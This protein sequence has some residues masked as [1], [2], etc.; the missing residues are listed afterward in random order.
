MGDSSSSLVTEPAARAEIR[1]PLAAGATLVL[2]SCCAPAGTHASSNNPNQTE[3]AVLMII[4]TTIY[5]TIIVSPG[6]SLTFC[7][8]FFPSLTSL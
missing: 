4:T 3:L 5:G 7:V 2:L 8:M 6:C 1:G